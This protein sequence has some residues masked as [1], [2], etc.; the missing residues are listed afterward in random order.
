MEMG[1]VVY[2]IT[3]FLPIINNKGAAFKGQMPSVW[4]LGG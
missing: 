4:M 3:E 2:V 1:F